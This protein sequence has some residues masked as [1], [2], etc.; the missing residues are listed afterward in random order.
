[1]RN[2]DIIRQMSLEE[3]APFFVHEKT[4]MDLGNMFTVYESPSGRRYL[5]YENAV[6]DCIDWLDSEQS[7]LSISLRDRLNKIDK[8]FDELTTEEFEKVVHENEGK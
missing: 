4:V 3:L 1:M 7:K 2:I 8:F 6:R 5:C